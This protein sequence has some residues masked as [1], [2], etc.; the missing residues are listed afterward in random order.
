[1]MKPI[2]R[3]FETKILR[4]VAISYTLF[5]TIIMLL[6]FSGSSKITIPYFDKIVHGVIYSIFTLVWFLN[7]AQWSKKNKAT[8][9]LVSLVL[10]IYG[11][12]IEFIQGSFVANRTEDFWDVV[13]N[14]IGIIVGIILFYKVR[15]TFILKN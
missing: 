11:I 8:Y 1:M 13:A 2:K 15:D 10:F 6:P 4:I 7:V 5:V 9:I 12:I 14:S 3:L